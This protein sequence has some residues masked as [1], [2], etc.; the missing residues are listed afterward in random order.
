MHKLIRKRTGIRY[1]ISGVHKMM[2]FWGYSQKVPVR[3]HVRRASPD[4][5]AMFQEWA[6]HI[7]PKRISEGHV[8]AIQDGAIVTDDARP[9]NRILPRTYSLR[10]MEARTSCS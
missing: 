6:R 4:A 2:R 7:I 9:R 3:R 1:G 10:H 8:V 5:I